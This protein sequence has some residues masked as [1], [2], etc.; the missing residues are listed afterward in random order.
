MQQHVDVLVR[1][2]DLSDD[3]A[4]AAVH[5]GSWQAAYRG[6]VP[7]DFLDSL[8]V[9]RRT[10]VWREILAGS[11]L[12]RSGVFVLEDN[13]RVVGFPHICPSRDDDASPDVGEV[14]SIY[15]AATV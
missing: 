4:I 5:V 10:A 11:E 15:L 2:S 7:D 8:S 6:Q 12:P 13:G 14:S 1:P 3:V 9:E